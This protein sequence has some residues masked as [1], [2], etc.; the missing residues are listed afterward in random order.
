MKNCRD[1]CYAKDAG[2]I[3]YPGLPGHIKT[4]CT[5]SPGFKSTFC[6]EHNSR[7]CTTVD[8]NEIEGTV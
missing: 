3:S 5:A 1:V 6:N 2:S 4:G 7:S 8:S